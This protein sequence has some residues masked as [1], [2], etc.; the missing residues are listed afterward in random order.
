MGTALPLAATLENDHTL[1]AWRQNSVHVALSVRFENINNFPTPDGERGG[2][3]PQLDVPKCGRNPVIAAK[4][5]YWY[6][7]L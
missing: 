7:Q 2:K 1:Y 5:N 4:D 3:K 6:F